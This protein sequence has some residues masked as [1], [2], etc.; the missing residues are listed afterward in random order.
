MLFHK[1]PI[2]STVH[3]FWASSERLG[4]DLNVA[5]YAV[6]SVSRERT[7]VVGEGTRTEAGVCDGLV[8]TGWFV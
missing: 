1:H 8:E 2:N 3:N 6:G 7:F 4:E 5:C